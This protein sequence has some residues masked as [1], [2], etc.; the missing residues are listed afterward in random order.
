M[1][2][3]LV[4]SYGN[5]QQNMGLCLCVRATQGKCQKGASCVDNNKEVRKV[6][7]SVAGS[8]MR[9]RETTVPWVITDDDT[10]NRHLTP[11][12]KRS[13]MEQKHPT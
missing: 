6:P 10:W 7:V 13:T 4:L 1:T 8:V 11:T 2:A 9:L 5:V 3:D 12:S